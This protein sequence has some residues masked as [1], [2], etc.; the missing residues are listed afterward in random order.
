LRAYGKNTGMEGW[1]RRQHFPESP[2]IK[3]FQ[4]CPFFQASAVGYLEIMQ[5]V[6]A[7]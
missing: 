1:K 6:T 4:E 2:S 3:N 5:A 7:V